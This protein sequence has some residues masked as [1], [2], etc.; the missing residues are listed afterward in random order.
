MKSPVTSCFVIKK[1]GATYVT[2]PIVFF[3]NLNQDY[4]YKYTTLKTP[5]SSIRAF[6]FLIPK[7]D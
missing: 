7:K 2:P 3:P 1:R 5:K 6:L 4:G